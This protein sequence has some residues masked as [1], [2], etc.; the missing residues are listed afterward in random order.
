V[1]KKKT[2]IGWPRLSFCVCGASDAASIRRRRQEGEGLRETGYMEK[3]KEMK[4]KGGIKRKKR[5]ERNDNGVS[6]QLLS[7]KAGCQEIS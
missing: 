4:G 7:V 3:R 5:K 6:V 2:S 1:A